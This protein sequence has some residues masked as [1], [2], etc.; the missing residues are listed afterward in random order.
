MSG[1]IRENLARVESRIIA[2]CER[3]GRQR[4]EVTLVAVSKTFPAAALDE[5]IAAGVTNLGENR[6]QELKEKVGELERTAR[7]HLIGHLQSNKAKDAVKLFD[8]IQTIDSESLARRVDR[9][10]GELGRAIEIL[11]QVNIGREAQK[12]G[13][14]PEEVEAL[15]GSTRDLSNLKLVGL[16]A[17]PP[18]SDEANARSYFREMKTLRDDLEEKLGPGSLPELSFGM[19]VDFVCAIEEGASIVRVGRAIFGERG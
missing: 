9:L 19:N 15:V 2:A 10:A 1:P 11:V 3:A 4:D 8:V 12:N 7:F 18:L 17:I 13:V 14:E 5:A 16:M 6:I